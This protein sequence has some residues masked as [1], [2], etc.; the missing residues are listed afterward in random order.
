[1]FV[2]GYNSLIGADTDH[3]K[4]VI[5]LRSELLSSL[6]NT[7]REVLKIILLCFLF[8]EDFNDF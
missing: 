7:I 1:M 8:L 2:N 3:V 4:A 6:G 5:S